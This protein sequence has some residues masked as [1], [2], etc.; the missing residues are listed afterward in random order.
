MKINDPEYEDV[1]EDKRF[2]EGYTL[3][4]KKA[5]T[6]KLLT[7]INNTAPDFELND[8][9]NNLF[10]LSDQSG[11]VVLIDFWELWCS[12]CIQS[13]PHLNELNSKYGKEKFE[14]WS[15]VSESSSFRK[16]DTMVESKGINYAVLLGNEEVKKK[17]F[18]YGV[19]LYLVVDQSGKI[20]HA[21]YGYTQDIDK[22]IAE[23]VQ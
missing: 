10:K 6:N 23:L 13:I 4:P 3:E 16:I 11:K 7:L 9:Q 12:P 1:F 19:P 5:S 2:L 17:Y 18:V 21:Q 20:K 14:I 8:L 15:I 22:M